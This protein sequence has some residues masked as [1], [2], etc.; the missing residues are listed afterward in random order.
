VTAIWK[1]H[2]DGSVSIDG[3][4]IGRVAGQARDWGFVL[5]DYR[6]PGRTQPSGWLTK[7]DAAEMCARAHLEVPPRQAEDPPGHGYW[8]SGDES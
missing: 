6:D 5:A 7:R 3:E 1:L 2:R 4:V 8:E